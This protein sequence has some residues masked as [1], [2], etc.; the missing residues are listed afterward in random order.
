MRKKQETKTPDPYLML[1]T[2]KD[3]NIK[4]KTIKILDNK[5]E[6]F[7]SDNKRFLKQ[8]NKQALTLQRKSK[9]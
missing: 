6:C 7:R 8:T 4:D 5:K 1:H 9:K 2:V 3:L